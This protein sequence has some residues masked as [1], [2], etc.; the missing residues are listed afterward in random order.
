MNVVPPVNG[1]LECPA[2]G[3]V[4]ER[5]AT[6]GHIT[7]RPIGSAPGQAN[8]CPF[9]DGV[10]RPAVSPL[11]SGLSTDAGGCLQDLIVKLYELHVVVQSRHDGLWPEDPNPPFLG[12]ANPV[13]PPLHRPSHR[14]T[15]KPAT[16][17][18]LS[19]SRQMEV[20][21]SARLATFMHT[22]P[23]SEQKCSA[24]GQSLV[25]AACDGCG[26]CPECIAAG[27]TD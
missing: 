9:E 18:H 22:P 21:I 16:V 7:F 25:A 11:A 6:S 4:F 15:C 12:L 24:C 14:H 27:L 13:Q 17:R 8:A 10:A 1:V 26:L 2:C 5:I 20:T 3:K 19:P 23:I